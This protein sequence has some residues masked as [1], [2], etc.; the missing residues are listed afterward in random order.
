MGKLT[1]GNEAIKGFVTKQLVANY[2]RAH[3]ENDQ[4][5]EAIKRQIIEIEKKMERLVM[6]EINLDLFNKYSE[7]FKEEKLNL[8]RSL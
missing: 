8:E 7:K 1:F 5:K 6:E 2:N 4:N 3:K